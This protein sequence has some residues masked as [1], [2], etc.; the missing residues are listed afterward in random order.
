[1]AGQRITRHFGGI[2]ETFGNLSLAQVPERRLVKFHGHRGLAPRAE[3]AREAGGMVTVR[4][5]RDA[6]P[7]PDQQRS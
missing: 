4:D 3:R 1:M 6:S 7:A 5:R 2:K